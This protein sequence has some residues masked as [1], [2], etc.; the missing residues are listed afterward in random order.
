MTCRARL[1]L[2]LAA[3]LAAFEFSEE[4]FP[5]ADVLGGNFNQF[6]SVNILEVQDTATAH[7]ERFVA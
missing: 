7:V 1:G 4:A 3:V 2:D 5:Q 6:V